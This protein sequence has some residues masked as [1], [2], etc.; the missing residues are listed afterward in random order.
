MDNEHI[1][2]YNSYERV[3]YPRHD[4]EEFHGVRAWHKACRFSLHVKSVD[5]AASHLVNHSWEVTGAFEEG[6]TS[7]S[8]QTCTTPNADV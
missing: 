4:L 7:N 2:H 8:C 6:I 3:N 5:S 1:P